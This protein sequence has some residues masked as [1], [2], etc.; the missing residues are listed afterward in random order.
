MARCN[1]CSAP[2]PPNTQYCSYCGVRNDVD[3]HGKHDY[4]VVSQESERIC[5]EC[6]IHLQTIALAMQPPLH[7]E[8]CTHCFGLFFDPGEVETLLESAVSPVY[9]VNRELLGNINNDRY[10]RNKPVKYLECPVC[11]NIMNRVA[12][13]HKSGVVVDQCRAHGV[14]L[15][16][17]EISHLM[18]WKK[19]GGQILH[20]QKQAEL[21]QKNTQTGRAPLSVDA[22]SGNRYGGQYQATGGEEGLLDIVFGLIFKVFD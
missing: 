1:N 19:A 6:N 10:Q 11:L 17:G 18:E 2:L 22:G 21:Q 3:L 16:G 15:D 4:R 5:P 14:W 20:A 13:G 9:T 12:F 7:I 8:R